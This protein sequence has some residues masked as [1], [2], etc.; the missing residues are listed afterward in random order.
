[1]GIEKFFNS[2]KKSY[3]NK[4]ISS[5]NKSTF[6][7]D[8]YLLI[9]FNSIIH[10][11]SQSV[12]SSLV[13]LYHIHL[14][15]IIY[16]IIYQQQKI[17]IKYHIDNLT[18]IN[19]FILNLDISLSDSK[20]KSIKINFKND[21]NIIDESFFK[22]FNEDNLDKF[23]IHKVSEYVDQL[24]NY[25]PKLS[26][27]Y[28]AIDGVPLYSKM[29][30]QKK[31]RTIGH[32]LL[33]AR[34]T[35]LSLYQTELDIEQDIKQNIYYN[36]FEFEKKIINLKFNKNKISPGCKFLAN[37][38]IYIIKYFQY[39]TKSNLIKYQVEI[40]PFSN[41][42]EGEKK[43]VYK[44]HQLFKLGKITKSSHITTYSPDGDVI[45]LML[46]ELDKCIIQIMR[47]DQQLL[48]LDIININQLKKNIIEYMHFNFFNDQIQL[49]IIKDIVMLF[50][51]FGND[52]LPKLE[53]INPMKH[54]KIILD[55]YLKLSSNL[56]PNSE[57]K[58]IYI[59]SNYISPVSSTSSTLSTSSI[60][61][62]SSTF[63]ISESISNNKLQINWNQLLAFFIN[64]KKLLNQSINNTFYKRYQKEWKLESDQII[65]S[66]A[67]PYY[68][69][70]FNL[71][72]MTNMYNPIIENKIDN[73]TNISPKLINK[74]SLKYLQGFLWLNEYYLNHNFDYK[75]FYY[76][77]NIKPNIDQLIY[78]LN[79][80]IN[81]NQILLNKLIN[82]LN[83]TIILES[84]Y[85][86]PIL[87]LIYISPINILNIADQSLL[88]SNLIKIAIKWDQ[89]F[90]IKINLKIINNKINIYDY[91]NCVDATYISKCE[92]LNQ[93]KIF[94]K[95]ILT[96]L[97]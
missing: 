57:S 34:T 49:N 95:K 86:T 59:F 39:K 3:G 45:L 24:T 75:F 71:E 4:I 28:L 23:I 72:N 35:I 19:D 55:A 67:I 31:R 26:Y 58:Y 37:L 62:T 77:Y 13:Y 33:E 90:N 65:N 7:P 50:T 12:S 54:I 11:I 8:K 78:M 63:S 10:N 82:N 18:T 93:K 44:I 96:Y 29:I 97:T 16:P 42:G 25:F 92:L 51:I 47:Y 36:H 40:D 66:N 46:L 56:K 32:I 94:G 81:P 1:M 61:S 41:P 43:I 15:S 79:K 68:Q 85:F 20:I 21:L 74:I 2:I 14:I 80:L 60:S 38:Q 30:E 70:I 9:D 5:I 89:L 69:H 52:F 64:L 27:L 76:K 48:Q 88:N 22:L 91:L 83:H 53:I 17:N 84:K 73:S 87:Q 6:F